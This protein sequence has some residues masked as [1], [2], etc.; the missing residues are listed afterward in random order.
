VKAF[1]HQE[2]QFSPHS[3]MQQEQRSLTIC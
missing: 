1:Q 3:N 2:T